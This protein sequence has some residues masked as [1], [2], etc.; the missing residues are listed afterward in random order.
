MFDI[1][2]IDTVR[3]LIKFGSIKA[4]DGNR[5]IHSI[6]VGNDN[7]DNNWIQL[8]QPDSTSNANRQTESYR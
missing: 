8:R 2:H 5:R 3:G 7:E 4:F 1:V 6:C